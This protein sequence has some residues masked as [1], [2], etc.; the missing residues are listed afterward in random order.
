MVHIS[1]NPAFWSIWSFLKRGPTIKCAIVHPAHPPP[2]NPENGCDAKIVT[3]PLSVWVPGFVEAHRFSIIAKG[4][5]H[6]CSKSRILTAGNPSIKTTD[7]V[8][9]LHGRKFE[10][11]TR[12]M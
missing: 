12:K 4:T 11:D 6:F 8:P 2:S 10:S 7:K 3:M 1:K 5:H 9:E